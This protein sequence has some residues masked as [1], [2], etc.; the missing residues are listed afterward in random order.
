MSTMGVQGRGREQNLDRAEIAKF[1]GV[2][3]DW[4]NPKGIYK[5]LH[6]INPLRVE[7]IADRTGL[8]GRRILDVACGV[9]LL[10]EAMAHAGA[11]VTGIDMAPRVLEAARRHTRQSQLCITYVNSTVEAL[12]E[13]SK[14]RFDV[15]SCM[16]LLEHVPD[17]A[18]VVA[19]CSRLT[20]PG[21]DLFFATLNRT[22]KSF[23]FAI[24]GAEYVLRLLPVGTHRWSHFIKPSELKAWALKAAL[25][26]AGSSGLQY[27]PFTRRYRLGGDLQVNYLAHLKK[28]G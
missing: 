7:F 2:V 27:N 21:G 4:W 6:D 1:D 12:A 19:A 14:T 16:E 23:L 18:S 8:K 3:A 13:A 24:I 17:P 5:S 15:V 10:S 22:F 25:E 11:R 20:R 28:P 9:G 26:P